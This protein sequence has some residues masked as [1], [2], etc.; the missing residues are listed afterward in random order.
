MQIAAHCHLNLGR[1]GG[2]NKGLKA[3]L[4]LTSSD[5][6]QT[7]SRSLTVHD[8]QVICALFPSAVFLVQCLN[9]QVAQVLCAGPLKH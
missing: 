4:V 3:F 6:Q 8:S 5:Q 2:Q 9:F 1:G 7:L